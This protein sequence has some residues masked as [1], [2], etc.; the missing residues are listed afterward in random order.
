MKS[1]QLEL[2]EII[3]IDLLKNEWF[4]VELNLNIFPSF[5]HSK[6]F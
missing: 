2:C 4:I 6:L 3:I 1:K 5:I